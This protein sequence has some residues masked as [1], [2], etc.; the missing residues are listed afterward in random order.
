MLNDK[1]QNYKIRNALIGIIAA[2]VVAI[3]SI[4]ICAIVLNKGGE[5]TIVNESSRDS[6]ILSD[7]DLSRMK[8]EV[9]ALIRSANNTD[10]N[11]IDMA[12]R[13]DTLYQKDNGGVKQISVIA[14]V[15][16]YRQ[17]YQILLDEYYVYVACP[18]LEITKYPESYCV[19]NDGDYDD[20]TT[21]V[22][23]TSLPY[24]G[25]TS[26]GELFSISRYSWNRGDNR[27]SVQIQSCLDD[28]SVIERAEQAVDEYITSL[29]ASPNI[30]KKEFSANCSHGE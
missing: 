20:S 18:D 5:A 24:Q 3:V 4:S 1:I 8:K 30:F 12:L 25:E 14:D 21:V 27:L 13:W 19:G 15:D 11:T 6:S 2:F 7:A 17:T 9:Y 22:F 23:G 28:E 29:G 16:E 26:E 10:D